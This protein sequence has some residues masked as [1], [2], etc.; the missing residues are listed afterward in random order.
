M[1]FA[2]F[3]NNQLPDD[4]AFIY[5]RNSD[6]SID[7]TTIVSYGSAKKDNVVIPSGVTEIGDHAFY[8]SLLTSITIPNGVTTIG[9]YAFYYNNLTSVTIPQ[10]VTT[11]GSSAFSYAFKAN[12]STSITI[13]NSV[14][15]IGSSALWGSYSYLTITVDNKSGA[16][17][18][19]PWGA[20]PDKYSITY[21][22]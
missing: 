2:V 10:G 8:A 9:P 22:R 16:I 19:A 21:L 12:A 20:Y 4:Q 14:T 15:S 5:K 7:Y 17:S 13:P 3:N 18:G 11:I 6:G 1:G